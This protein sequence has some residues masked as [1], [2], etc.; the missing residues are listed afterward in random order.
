VPVAEDNLPPVVIHLKLR[1]ASPLPLALSLTTS[2]E[3]IIE[4]GAPMI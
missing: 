2:P 4:E 1:F 3:R